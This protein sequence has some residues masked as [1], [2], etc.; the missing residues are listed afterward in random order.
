MSGGTEAKNQGPENFHIQEAWLNG[1][2]LTRCWLKIEEFSA[3]NTLTLEMTD[4][5]CGFGA[6]GRPPSFKN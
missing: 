1:E 3:G 4:E 5:P 6:N 2:P